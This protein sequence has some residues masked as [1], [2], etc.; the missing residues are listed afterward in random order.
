[1]WREATLQF[2]AAIS[3][4]QRGGESLR[5]G[6]AR[7]MRGLFTDGGEKRALIGCTGR[8]CDRARTDT[9]GP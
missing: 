4:R 7:R 2:G 9:D 3:L 8:A 6:C 5:S 1:M